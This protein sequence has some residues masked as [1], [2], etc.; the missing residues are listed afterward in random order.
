V[1]INMLLDLEKEVVAYAAMRGLSIVPHVSPTQLHGLEI[2]PYAQQ[3]AQVV[4]WIGYLQWMHYNG[5]KMPDHPVLT[6]IETIRQMDAILD[7]SDPEHPKEPEWPEAEFIV[8][9]PPFLGGNKVR[10]ELG[11][12]YV[13]KLFQLYGGRVPAFSDLCCYWFERGRQ[14]I[15]LG[16]CR[17]AGLLATQ[18]IRGGVNRTVLQRIKSGGDIFFAES[19]RNWVLEGANVHVSMIGFDCGEEKLRRLNGKTVQTINPNLTALADLTTARKLLANAN[20]CCYGSQQKA[21]MDIGPAVAVEMLLAPNPSGLPNSDVIRPSVNASQVLRRTHES[22]VIDFGMEEDI[23]KA[24]V[25][26]APFEFL[27]RHVYPTRKDH[28]EP[29]QRNFWWLHARPSPRYRAALKELSRYVASPCVS[30]HRI[31]VWMAA[32]DLVDHALVV[33][34]SAEGSLFGALQS[35][36]HELWARAQG[37]QVREAESGFRYTPSSCFD[38]FPM[39]QGTPEQSAAI[40]AAAKELDD[41]RCRWLNPPE[42]TKTEVLEFPGSVGGPWARYVVEPDAR[43]IG[44]VRWPRVVP[45]DPDCAASLKQ[46]TLTNLYNQRPAWLALAHKKLDEAVFAA[47]GW[48]AGMSDEE[49]LESL[50]KLNLERAESE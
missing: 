29:C 47:Y 30:K 27:R 40:A 44:T 22:F 18:G 25:Y 41:L 35:R 37:T 43:G 7:L 14:Q 11:D 32:M 49:L 21:D 6:P 20:L 42:W 9:N 5:F 13:D 28:R 15:E 45:K 19:D 39:P 10:A 8:G 26:E 16:R 3:L 4:I 46:R 50:L 24:S 23:A 12:Q 34:C 2:N 48:D 38:T 36:A 33:F 1:A 31:F 17:R